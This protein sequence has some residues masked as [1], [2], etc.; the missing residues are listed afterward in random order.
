MLTGMNILVVEDDMLNQKIVSYILLKKGAIVELAIDGHEAIQLLSKNK[1][2]VILMDLQMP[3]MDG[4][5]ASVYIR[6]TMKINVPI[7]ALTADPFADKNEQYLAA[8][9]NA[10]I[11]KPVDP[12]SLYDL[13]LNLCNKN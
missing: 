8:G 12:N 5:D 1:F 9:I 3:G 7:I 11:C 13:I 10:C 4:Y 2:D 6:N